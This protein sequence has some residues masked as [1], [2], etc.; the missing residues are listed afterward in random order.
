MCTVLRQ[1]LNQNPENPLNEMRK[2]S[3]VACSPVLMHFYIPT[4]KMEGALNNKDNTKNK[5]IIM[6]VSPSKSSWELNQELIPGSEK[7]VL[8]SR[9]PNG[10][11]KQDEND[12]FDLT[13]KN[14]L[15]DGRISR[16]GH[17]ADT[18]FILKSMK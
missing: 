16:L 18:S 14:S 1:Y 2:S 8:Q 5:G 17:Y 13:E 10:H 4:S 11:S 3:P 7:P 15:K 9:Y 12:E 6:R